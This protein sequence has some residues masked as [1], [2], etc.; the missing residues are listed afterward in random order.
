MIGEL[1]KRGYQRLRV[2]PYISASG[3]HWRCF[4]GPVE[5]FYRNHGAMLREFT[6]ANP[7]RY[8][9]AQQNGYFGWNDAGQDDAR[10]LADK[11]VER[12]A[13]LAEKGKGWDYPYAGWYVHM[14]GLADNGWMPL[15]YAEN[16]NT[17]FN[18]VP[19]KDV[20]PDA[21]KDDSRDLNAFL[22]M[23]PAGALEEDH[24]YYTEP[25]VVD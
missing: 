1:H 5:A 19:L 11:F 7:A 13:N 2:M 12:F 18:H 16:V 25:T 15:V 6:A 22:P 17:S 23:P 14:L 20:R 21:W 9:T 3:G 24:P 10:S 4:I 8:S